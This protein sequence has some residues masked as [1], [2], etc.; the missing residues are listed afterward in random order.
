MAASY[1]E[2]AQFIKHIQ[3]QKTVKTQNIQELR[4]VKIKLKYNLKYN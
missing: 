3:T 1:T 4:E 2:K